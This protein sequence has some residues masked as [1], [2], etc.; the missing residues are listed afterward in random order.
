M[1]T[2]LVLCSPVNEA[3]GPTRE[4]VQLQKALLQ[5]PSASES[6]LHTRVVGLVCCW[7]VLSTLTM[8]DNRKLHQVWC[9]RPSMITYQLSL[10]CESAAL[11][12]VLTDKNPQ[13]ETF[14]QMNSFRVL[15]GFFTIFQ[16]VRG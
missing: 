4:F 8:C 9:D 16:A 1:G 10:L 11:L 6:T 13:Q 7:V 12:C 14:V 5:P 3:S 2:T 15:G